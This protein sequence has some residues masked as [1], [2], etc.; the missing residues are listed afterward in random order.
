MTYVPP[1]ECNSESPN[2]PDGGL[3]RAGGSPEER[4]GC[5][6]RVLRAVAD[7]LSRHRAPGPMLDS[8]LGLLVEKLGFEAGWAFLRREPEGFFVASTC[9]VPSGLAANGYAGLSWWPCACQRRLLTVNPTAAI[10]L[11]R[12]ERLE[13]TA[14][15]GLPTDSL[16]S[17]VSVPLG[18]GG[19]FS[20]S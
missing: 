2:P 18:A 17:H 16:Q 7:E 8:I 9:R 1:S 14:A 12:C 4:L 3:A 10:W 19:R 11:D 6:L 13:R 5:H 15:A 20:D